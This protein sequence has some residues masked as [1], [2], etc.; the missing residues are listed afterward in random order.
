MPDVIEELKTAHR[1][2]TPPAPL[3][4]S[5]P[6]RR[7]QRRRRRRRI[8]NAGVSAGVTAGLVVGGLVLPGAS[9][10]SP[11]PAEEPTFAILGEPQREIDKLPQSVRQQQQGSLDLSSTRLI[12][13]YDVLRYWLGTTDDGDF[14]VI[15][16][17]SGTWL[18]TTCGA[19][20][21]GWLNSA[22]RTT[23]GITTAF[24]FSDGME[25]GIA[26]HAG[27]TV[28]SDNLA[29]SRMPDG[30]R[31][32][33]VALLEDAAE[34]FSVFAEPQRPSDRLPAVQ[35]PADW[36]VQEATTRYV[37]EYGDVRYWIGALRTD[38]PEEYLQVCLIGITG[39]GEWRGTS[40]SHPLNASKV[41]PPWPLER[42]DPEDSTQLALVPDDYELTDVQAGTWE[43]VAPN[44]YHDTGAERR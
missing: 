18:S 38:P 25:L 7:G 28:V 4:L 34:D 40:C 24:V 35:N 16:A 6:I 39:G 14:C 21:G 9:S 44:L 41:E 20:I 5:D 10:D 26:Q 36:T 12:G 32:E 3:D 8:A 37:G 2:S 19:G 22:H 30:Q 29:I 23:Y 42:T 15:G 11:E 17:E 27:F 43:Q 31:E 13:E 1:N 33:L